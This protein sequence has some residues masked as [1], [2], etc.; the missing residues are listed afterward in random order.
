VNRVEL[1]GG[2]KMKAAALLVASL[3]TLLLA[4]AMHLPWPNLSE[5]ANWVLGALI[6]VP[7]IVALLVID[8]EE[9]RAW[10]SHSCGY[11]PLTYQAP[12]R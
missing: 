3:A 10:T 1:A 7:I 2:R 12:P 5:P 4:L 8:R 11:R 6:V 9:K